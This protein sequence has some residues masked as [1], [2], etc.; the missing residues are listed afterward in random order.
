MYCLCLLGECRDSDPRT[1]PYVAVH[2]F[3]PMHPL[4]LWTVWFGHRTGLLG[5]GKK[6]NGFQSKMTK[7]QAPNSHDKS[8]W[9]LEFLSVVVKLRQVCRPYAEAS[10]S[11]LR[12]S[13]SFLILISARVPMVRLTRMAVESR[14]GWNLHHDA[15]DVI[16]SNNFECWHHFGDV[17]LQWYTVSSVRHTDHTGKERVFPSS[18]LI[19][20][21]WTATCADL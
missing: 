5:F 16:N 14:L 6:N 7:K 8:K 10:S 9:V 11:L 12:K 17:D 15:S 18:L 21:S 2:P 3:H 13:G 1:M 20:A 19:W 4:L